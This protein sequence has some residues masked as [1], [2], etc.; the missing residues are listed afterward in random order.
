MIDPGGP[1]FPGGYAGIDAA[2]E[3]VYVGMT[4]RDYFAAAALMVATQNIWDSHKMEHVAKR[5]Y[6][7][8][9]AMIAAR[10]NEEDR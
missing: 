5:C 10:Q 8:A 3:D 6:Q 2:G 9:D 1:A 7:Y 4:L